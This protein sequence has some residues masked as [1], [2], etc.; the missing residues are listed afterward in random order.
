MEGSA[1]LLPEKNLDVTKNGQI[2]WINP[3]LGVIFSWKCMET[4]K[5]CI[6]FAHNKA[7]DLKRT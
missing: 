1:T 5:R 6:D 3:F 2:Y 7:N 4:V